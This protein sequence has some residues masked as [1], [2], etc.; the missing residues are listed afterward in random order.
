MP[1]ATALAEKHDD[2]ERKNID[3]SRPL[4][5]GLELMNGQGPAY[6][7]L[8]ELALL[9]GF[10]SPEQ[11][12]DVGDRVIAGY[13]M[14]SSEATVQSVKDGYQAG[15]R[16]VEN[17]ASLTPEQKTRILAGMEKGYSRNL[18]RM[19]SAEQD[20]PAIR[21]NLSALKELLE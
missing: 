6:D 7:D 17:D 1:Q 10:S 8:A 11:W 19:E 21:T 16:N 14:A 18:T 2:G 12:A 15:R 20:L 3:P 9:Y 5:S 4:S 13:P